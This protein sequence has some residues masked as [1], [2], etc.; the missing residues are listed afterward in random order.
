VALFLPPLVLVI[1]LL[2]MIPYTYF[3]KRARNMLNV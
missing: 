1:P 3:L 2:F